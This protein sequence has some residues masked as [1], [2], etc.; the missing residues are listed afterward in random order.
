MQGGATMSQ[1]ETKK[2]K[3]VSSRKVEPPTKTSMV[4]MGFVL[5]ALVLAAVG[6]REPFMVSRVLM[7][8]LA[9]IVCAAP[10]VFLALGKKRDAREAEV[11]A[12]N[13][14]KRQEQTRR[15]LR[16]MMKS[17][18]EA[19][20]MRVAANDDPEARRVAIAQFA[21]EELLPNVSHGILASER[22]LWLQEVQ[23][24]AETLLGRAAPA[25]QLELTLMVGPSPS[26]VLMD[27]C[28][29]QVATAGWEAV[30]DGDAVTAQEGAAQAFFQCLHADAPIEEAS[31]V[32]FVAR[33][34]AA[35]VR[36]GAIVANQAFQPAALQAARAH[37]VGLIR[38]AHVPTFLEWVSR[39]Q[40][41]EPKRA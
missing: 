8:V 1:S 28:M 4:Q 22:P 41:P 27:A 9:A 13:A 16:R 20:R 17:Q 3:R 35:G 7:F 36:R 34:K 11:N 15:E 30:V 39:A 24:Y 21:A 32:A 26:Q 6:L 19:L 5:A 18:V 2:I 23:G 14:A 29:A 33:L 40:T 38:P 12:D 25:P 10:F 37:G 31:V